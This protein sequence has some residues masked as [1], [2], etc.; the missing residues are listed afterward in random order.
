MTNDQFRHYVRAHN[1]EHRADPSAVRR[2]LAPLIDRAHQAGTI[3]VAGSSAWQHLPGRDPRKL[4]A[5]AQA[6]LAW[7]D[8]STPAAIAA[9]LAAECDRT[10]AAILTRQKATSADLSAAWTDQRRFSYGPSHLEL[11]L[12]R[13]QPGPGY[14][15]QL[16]PHE[17]ARINR[18]SRAV[19]LH[20]EL[21]AD[22]QLTV[23]D[24]QLRAIAPIDHADREDNAA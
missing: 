2:W 22:P 6:A 9:R 18:L 7:L 17:Q 4:A 5:V 21:L 24:A 19:R 14:N 20:R 12:R 11:E 8:D 3:P 15:G 13:A 1:A 16:A 10:D 23:R